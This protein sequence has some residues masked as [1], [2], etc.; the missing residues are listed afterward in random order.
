M[1]TLTRPVFAPLF[2]ISKPTTSV[3]YIKPSSSRSS[4]FNFG[5]TEETGKHTS[6]NKVG[7]NSTA[8]NTKSYCC[9]QETETVTSSSGVT[10]SVIT[11]RKSHSFLSLHQVPNSVF[12]VR[13]P[14]V[15]LT[16][17]RW[18]EPSESAKLAVCMEKLSLKDFP[19]HVT[20]GAKS[21]LAFAQKP[22]ANDDAN[23]NMSSRSPVSLTSAVIL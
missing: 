7:A 3:A 21:Q 20:R 13:S 19:L 9:A 1:D 4:A 11:S 6:P 8:A 22:T 14:A 5:S 16:N 2:T 17:G 15:T 23:C 12:F 18:P 10:S